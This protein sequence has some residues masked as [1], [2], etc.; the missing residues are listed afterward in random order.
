GFGTYNQ[1]S[2]GVKAKHWLYEATSNGPSIT[3]YGPFP[4][5]GNQDVFGLNWSCTSGD[6]TGCAAGN[7]ADLPDTWER[8]RVQRLPKGGI[9][10]TTTIADFFVRNSS[11]TTYKVRYAPLAGSYGANLTVTVSVWKCSNSDC[12]SNSAVAGSPA[13]V[14]FKQVTRSDG[15]PGA[16][17]L[18]WDNGDNRNNP[19]LG[20]FTQGTVSD[21]TIDA[22]HTCDGWDPNND[23]NSDK[24][25]SYDLRFPTDSSDSRGASFT[26][27]DVI[28]LDWKSGK[29]HKTDILS[30]LAPNYPSAPPDFRI[31]TYLKDSR[32]AGESF[33]HLKDDRPNALDAKRPLFANGSTPIGASM[34]AFRTWYNGCT[35]TG[36]CAGTGRWVATASNPNASIGDTSF[37]CRQKYLL[38]LTDGD[39]TCGGDPCA[40][41]TRLRSEGVTIFVVAFGVENSSG[42]KLNCMGDADHIFYPQDE[43][44]LVSDLQKAIGSI[45]ED[46][47]AFASAAVPSVQAEVADRIFLSSFRPIGDRDPVT[48]EPAAVWDGHLDA[49]LKPLPLKNGKPDRSRVCPAVGGS[50]PRTSCFLWDAGDV[51][52]TQAPTKSAL[53]A[54]SSLDQTTLRL[55]LNTDQRR[56]FYPKANTGSG[57]PSTL[58]LLVPPTGNIK[59][60]PDWSDLWTGLKVLPA[61]PTFPAVLTDP[62]Y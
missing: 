32:L 42:N 44:E 54:A 50:Q 40:M 5:I 55:G 53:S 22:N 25:N 28:P 52:V 9:S 29:D 37:R 47:R 17:F 31:A 41:A 27:G 38:I 18:S 19:Q 62:Q 23:T 4:A 10:F 59:T 12:S 58:R 26:V 51:L 30:R 33:L 1:D 45:S 39:E 49:Y 21:S 6:D 36:D 7:P 24:A 34:A 11:G 2:L 14:G 16:D 56:V 3:G 8:S 15:L 61:F 48:D 46:P 13:V 57:I 60:D 43:D 35:G 20:Y